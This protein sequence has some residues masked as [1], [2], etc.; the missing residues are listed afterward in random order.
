[1]NFFTLTKTGRTLLLAAVLALFAVVWF[2]CGDGTNPGGGGGGG[3]TSSFTLKDIPA[4]YSGKYLYF[5]T[6]GCSDGTIIGLD[7][8]R[9]AAYP[10]SETNPRWI[11]GQINNG[12][13]NL[14]V[15]YV[16]PTDKMGE[17]YT[18][19]CTSAIG[20]SIFNT[21]TFSNGLFIPSECIAMTYIQP[22]TFSRGSAAVSAKNVEWHANEDD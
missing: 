9:D 22:V 16:T 17:K 18:G 13:V 20:V 2:G 19:N 7:E 3:G 6:A 21:P 12:Y 8:Y 4:E 15:Y 5:Q 1:M 11:L 14:S 10:L